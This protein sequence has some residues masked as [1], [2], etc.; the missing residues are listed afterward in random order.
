MCIDCVFLAVSV[1]LQHVLVVY[2]VILVVDIELFFMYI[3][4]VLRMCEAMD[5]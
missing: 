4:Q 2:L 3:F 5:S 1:S